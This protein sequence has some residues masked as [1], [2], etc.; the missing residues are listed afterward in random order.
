MKYDLQTQELPL[1]GVVAGKSLA[2]FESEIVN[3][4]WSIFPSVLSRMEVTAM[5]AD[6]LKWIKKCSELQVRSGINKNGDGTAHHAIGGNDSLDV[7]FHKHIMHK[8]ISNFFGGKPYIM[9]AAN[10]V[11]GFPGSTNYVHIIHR[12]VKTIIPNYRFRLNMIVMLDEFTLENGATEI[13][14]NS[15]TLNAAPSLSDFNSKSVRLL[16]GAG[17]IVLFDSYLWHKAGVNYTQNPRV[18]FTLSF[19]PAFIKPQLDYARMFGEHLGGGFSDLSRQVLGY[20]SR[21][22]HNLD[23]WYRPVEKRFYRSDQ[24]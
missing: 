18:A 13:I 15:Q 5:R 3:P 19:N 12:D 4:G 1:D 9:H 16:G 6:C 7:F 2:D 20:N 23:E 22:P 14:P 21:V 11:G 17:T 10:P 24:G 8:Y